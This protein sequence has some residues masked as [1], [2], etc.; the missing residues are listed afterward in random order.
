MLVFNSR[1]SFAIWCLRQI[2]TDEI[3]LPYYL[4]DF[5]SLKKTGH[6]FDFDNFVIKFW[7][8]WLCA[9]KYKSEP[10]AVL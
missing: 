1:H 10:N 5:K 4:K 9:N 8:F 2:V 6:V 7:S 3:A